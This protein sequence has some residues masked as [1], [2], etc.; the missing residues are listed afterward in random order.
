MAT[1]IL[2][3][4]K[5]ILDPANTCLVL[6]DVQNAL[7]KNSFNKDEFLSNLKNLLAAARKAAVPVVY[8]RITP[9]PPE[10]QSGWGLYRNMQR[11]GVTDPKKLPRFMAPGSPEAEIYT[12]VSPVEGDFIIHKHFASIFVGT[13][14]ESMMRNRRV[15]T[16]LFTGIST[17]I[18]IDS[19][20][21]DAGNR[22]FYPVVVSDCVSSSSKDMHDAALKVLPAVSLV[23]PSTK[24]IEQWG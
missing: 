2:T 23:M 5:D 11:A 12:E 7:V 17:E 4:M 18:G 15:E 10:Y 3:D 21:R 24:I 8:T 1:R 19:N 13:E 6:W 20:A 14:F 16:L 9:L 22:G